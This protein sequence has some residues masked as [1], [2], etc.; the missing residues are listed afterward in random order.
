MIVSCSLCCVNSR[1][2]AGALACCQLLNVVMTL[3]H[4][5]L[6]SGLLYRVILPT[7]NT[8]LHWLKDMPH[9]QEHAAGTITIAAYERAVSSRTLRCRDMLQA[10][11]ALLHVYA[12]HGQ[13]E[14][15]KQLFLSMQERGPAVD[16]LSASTLVAAYAKACHLASV[17]HAWHV[18]LSL[19]ISCQ[20]WCQAGLVWQQSH[21]LAEHL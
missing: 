7:S 18:E 4:S 21:V 15:A 9:L 17:A 12:S 8:R 20:S 5:A 2:Y 11:N 14:K 13:V 1:K 19:S 6:W 3:K 16:S 10:H